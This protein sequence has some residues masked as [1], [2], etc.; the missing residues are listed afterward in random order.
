M[1]YG[2]GHII[3]ALK[4]EERNNVIYGGDS[5]FKLSVRLNV[6]LLTK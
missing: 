6:K 1:R 3:I 4:R 5:C 2:K